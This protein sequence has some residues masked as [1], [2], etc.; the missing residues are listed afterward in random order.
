[1]RVFFPPCPQAK[2]TQ[3]VYSSP[4]LSGSQFIDGV[5]IQRDLGQAVQQR[6]VP[7]IYVLGSP[8]LLRVD[9]LIVFH[10]DM[11]GVVIVVREHFVSG[12]LQ[13]FV[14]HLHGALVVPSTKVTLTVANGGEPIAIGHLHDGMVG[15]QQ[16]QES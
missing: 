14:V 6:L 2:S 15:S 4:Y 13:S 12:R 11:Q 7:S 5:V 10:L 1:M 3:S 16:D 9:D 8:L